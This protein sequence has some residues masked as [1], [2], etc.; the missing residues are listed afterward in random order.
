[1]PFSENPNSLS[2]QAYQKIRQKIVTLHLSPGS[3]LDE[4]TLQSELE[5]GRTP[6]REALKRLE[7]ENL[8]KI[9]PRRGMFVADINILDL[10]RLYEVRLTLEPLAANLAA[11]RGQRVHWHQMEEALSR[12]SLGQVSQNNL[13]VDIDEACHHIIYAA[14]DNDYL[15]NMLTILYTLSLRMWYFAL[16]KKTTDIQRPIVESTHIDDHILIFEALKERDNY[17]AAD[18]MQKHIRLYQNDLQRIILEP[19]DNFIK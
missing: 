2:Y 7:I 19:M 5:L 8:V 10:Q 17:L 1:M 4:S 15:K 16:A 14:A 12:R 9:L 6:I 18:L 11:V 13:D 3:I